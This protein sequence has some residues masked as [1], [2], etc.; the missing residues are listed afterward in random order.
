MTSFSPGLAV[1]S[2]AKSFGSPFVPFSPGV[3]AFV[4][5]LAVNSS[6]SNTTLEVGVEPT[7]LTGTYTFTEISSITFPVALSLYL[8]V[9][10]TGVC[11]PFLSVFGVTIASSVMNGVTPSGTFVNLAIALLT[12]AR[13]ESINFSL[14][15]PF[16]TVTPFGSGFGRTLTVTS[17]GSS[18]LNLSAP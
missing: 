15:V 3:T 5:S 4:I 17:T 18:R 16:K 14:D 11:C 10:V 9:T 7:T 12:F 1:I 6:P 13:I 8:T 2:F